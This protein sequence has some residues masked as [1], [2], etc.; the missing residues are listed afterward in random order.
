MLLLL[1]L[2]LEMLITQ[3]LLKML[4]LL[5]P[6]KVLLLPLLL[7]ILLLPPL[8]E[9]ILLEMLLMQPL[10]EMSLLKLPFVVMSNEQAVKIEKCV[11]K[12]QAEEKEQKNIRGNKANPSEGVDR[13]KFSTESRQK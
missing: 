5:T 2:F 6:L 13:G 9:I 12:G 11:K 3:P 4:L 7:G 10:Q 8:H 1:Q